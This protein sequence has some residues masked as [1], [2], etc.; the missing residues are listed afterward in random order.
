M[1]A[2]CRA[3]SRTA[4]TG[5]CSRNGVLVLALLAG[6]VA[7]RVRRQDE[8]LIP[9]YAVGVFIVVH[10][11]AG[12]GWSDITKRND[13]PRWQRCI[14]DQR[15]RRVS[16]PRS[17]PSSSRSTKFTEGAWVPIIVIP[18]I[19]VLFHSIKQHY[20]D[21]S[22]KD[23]R[24]TTDYQPR[25]MNHTVVVLVGNVHRGVLEA[26][27]Y[28]RS[29]HPDHL[30][31]VTVVSD[32]EEQERDRAGVERAASI[33]IPLEIVHSPYRELTRPVLR[34]ID[35]LDARYDEQ[36]HHGRPP[37]VRRRLVVGPAA[38]QP[39]RPDPEGPPA[40]PQGHGR[41]LGAVPPRKID[42]VGSRLT[43]WV[44]KT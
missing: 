26:L 34:F 44:G 35:E 37:R 25:R 29:L 16:R 18:L 3:S 7:R 20:D 23:S 19:V 11:V 32:E 39:E 36:H 13:E 17:S 42:D 33:D 43:F 24:C 6:D 8:Q 15:C 5:W 22:P 41:H 4:A 10:A 12:W 28:A 9:L 40:V 21:V 2:T 30:L 38:P 14:V 1:T 31:A 27:A